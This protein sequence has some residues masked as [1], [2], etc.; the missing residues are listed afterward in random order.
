MSNVSMI[1]PTHSAIA[2][3]DKKPTR[4]QKIVGVV[5]LTDGPGEESVYARAANGRVNVKMQ[6]RSI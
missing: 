4:P 6:R 5:Q 1:N 2:R 3:F